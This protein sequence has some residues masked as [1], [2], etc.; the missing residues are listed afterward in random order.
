MY[1]LLVI[2][3]RYI[4]KLDI[5]KIRLADFSYNFN[6][7]RQTLL[8]VILQGDGVAIIPTLAKKITSELVEVTW[9]P[10]KRDTVSVRDIIA[11]TSSC[12]QDNLRTPLGW[13]PVTCRRHV[14]V[15]YSLHNP[16]GLTFLRI[17]LSH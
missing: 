12:P 16:K 15:V 11:V 13:S 6:K 1:R 14:P 10:R 3:T 17:R 8:D 2:I 4:N 7:T 9:D 5:Y